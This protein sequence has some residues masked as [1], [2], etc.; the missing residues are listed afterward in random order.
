MRPVSNEDKRAWCEKFG[1]KTEADFCRWA[2]MTLDMP[3]AVNPAKRTDQYTFDLIYD[4]NPADLKT[5][6]TPF[7]RADAL[8]KLDPQYTVTF[9]RKD[10][11]RYQELYP[12]IKVIFDVLW[13]EGM[14]YQPTP[15]SQPVTVE[16]MRLIAVGTLTEIWKA[17]EESGRHRHEYQARVCDQSGNAKESWLLDVRKL[18]VLHHADCR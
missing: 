16:P 3:V 1:P 11:Q 14:K 7:Y 5:V 17:I 15:D 10:G 18:T 6:R 2:F 8:Y 9:N 13:G 4:G 12:D